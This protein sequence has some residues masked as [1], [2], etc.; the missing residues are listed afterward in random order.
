VYVLADFKKVEKEMKTTQPFIFFPELNRQC[1][2]VPK[3][4]K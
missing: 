1:E 2:D 4:N 3:E